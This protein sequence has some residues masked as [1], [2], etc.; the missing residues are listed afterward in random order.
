VTVILDC[1]F[2]ATVMDAAKHWNLWRDSDAVQDSGI[3]EHLTEATTEEQRRLLAARAARE[4]DSRLPAGISVVWSRRDRVGIERRAATR[5]LALAPHFA[6]RESVGDVPAAAVDGLFAAA[7][8]FSASNRGV[9]PLSS[10]GAE[11]PNAAPLTVYQAGRRVAWETFAPGGTGGVFTSA[12]CAALEDVCNEREARVRGGPRPAAKLP[13]LVHPSLAMLHESVCRK[14]FF[15]PFRS[16]KPLL[17][18]S[19]TVQLAEPCGLL[20]AANV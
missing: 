20:S 19:S 12:L 10:A 18:T 2:E 9:T 4:S 6:S 1:G 14:L 13:G 17:R 7:A 5:C 3:T 16:Q 11:D 15:G 8:P